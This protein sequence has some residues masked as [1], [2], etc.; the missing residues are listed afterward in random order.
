MYYEYFLNIDVSMY[1]NKKK[2]QGMMEIM[3]VRLDCVK[4]ILAAFYYERERFKSIVPR[5]DDIMEDIN[6][7]HKIDSL[8]DENSLNKLNEAA[9]EMEEDHFGRQEDPHREINANDGFDHLQQIKVL[10]FWRTKESSDDKWRRKLKKR[11]ENETEMFLD[12]HIIPERPKFKQLL[13]NLK[14]LIEQEEVQFPSFYQ[15][16]RNKEH[17]HIGNDLSVILFYLIRGDECTNH[18][19]ES[20]DKDKMRLQ[21]IILYKN[22][23][24]TGVMGNIQIQCDILN[25]LIKRV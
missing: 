9:Y 15:I 4:K 17:Q 12:S 16:V 19:K 24:T 25:H 3:G 14:E 7:F 5:I 18:T 23:Q 6:I 22:L 1:H 2:V 13:R 11:L 21:C 10:A 20:D 8:L